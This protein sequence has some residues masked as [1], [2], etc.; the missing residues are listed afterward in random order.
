MKPW[1]KILMWFGLGATVGFFAGQQAGYNK[2]KDEDEAIINDAYERGKDDGYNCT[3]EGSMKQL[4]EQVAQAKNSLRQFSE[5][6]GYS[7]DPGVP[8]D[9][10]DAEMPMEPPEM[11]DECDEETTE[12][13]TEE[14]PFHPTMLAPEIVTEEQFAS[15]DDLNEEL[16]LWYQL[17]DVLYDCSDQKPMG[18][19]DQATSIG[20]GTL[21]EF[22]AGP[23][24]KDEIYVINE[25]YASKFRIQRIED[26]FM[27]A[28]D[29]TAGPDEDDDDAE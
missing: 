23:E 9:E 5:A 3:F 8:I 17:D 11:P 10:E 12:I 4:N 28:V 29:G 19:E 14:L 15:R 24:V 22:F 26:A 27:D 25:T 1:M 20:V 6:Y 21:N 7:E 13:N 16:L 2:A 18:P